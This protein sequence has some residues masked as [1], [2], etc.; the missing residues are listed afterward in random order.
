MGQNPGIC[1]ISGNPPLRS[2]RNLCGFSFGDSAESHRNLGFP[3]TFDFPNGVSDLRYFRHLWALWHACNT[4]WGCCYVP[5]PLYLEYIP[6]KVC[7]FAF[8]DPCRSSFDDHFAGQKS[9]FLFYWRGSR[10]L[11]FRKKLYQHSW[12]PSRQRDSPDQS[13]VG[14]YNYSVSTCALYCFWYCLWMPQSLL[15]SAVRAHHNWRPCLS[16]CHRWLL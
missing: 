7:R 11:S 3:K 5:C 2:S 4:R 12:R 6:Q 15:I 13:P 10:L 8:H 1:S 16:C 9:S 14:E